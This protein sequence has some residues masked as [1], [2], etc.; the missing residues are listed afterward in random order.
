MGDEC[1]INYKP[2]PDGERFYLH[3]LVNNDQH[4]CW[5]VNWRKL[6][7]ETR[8]RITTQWRFSFGRNTIIQPISD[9]FRSMSTRLRFKISPAIFAEPTWIEEPRDTI[10]TNFSM[11]AIYTT[12]NF[13]LQEWCCTQE[14]RGEW[15]IARFSWEVRG[16]NIGRKEWRQK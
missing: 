16:N 1:L 14:Y 9:S 6:I 10:L 12:L 15:K 13:V 8:A 11:F 7:D 3:L 5:P 2:V 4:N